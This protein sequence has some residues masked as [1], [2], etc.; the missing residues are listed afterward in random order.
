MGKYDKPGTLPLFIKR[1]VEEEPTP[2]AAISRIT[3]ALPYWSVN[4]LREGALADRGAYQDRKYQ[5]R[6]DNLI[7]YTGEQHG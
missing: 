5:T 3:S 7:Q 6:L 1:I 4:A 2:E